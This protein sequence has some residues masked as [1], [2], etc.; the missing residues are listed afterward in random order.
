MSGSQEKRKSEYVQNVNLHIGTKIEN[1][2]GI[3]AI[4]NRIN[5]KNYVGSSK[6]I[7]HRIREH[8]SS[9]KKGNHY[10]SHL[11]HSYNKYGEEAFIFQQLEIVD[12]IEQRLVREELWINKTNSF[13]SGYNKCCKPTKTTLGFKH[14]EETSKSEISMTIIFIITFVSW[15]LLR[16]T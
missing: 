1:V 3:Y 8:K 13:I 14:S 4:I 9:L 2:P 6:N 11:Q 12:D 7:E 16:I 15:E 10:N 5:N